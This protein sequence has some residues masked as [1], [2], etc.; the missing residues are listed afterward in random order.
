MPIG[1]ERWPTSGSGCRRTELAFGWLATASPRGRAAAPIW[2]S[3]SRRLGKLTRSLS[4]G[5]ARA[6]Y[7]SHAEPYSATFDSPIEPA[8][9]DAAVRDYRTRISDA[10]PASTNVSVRVTQN[11][12]GPPPCVARARAAQRSVRRRLQIRLMRRHER[13]QV[14]V[15]AAASAADRDLEGG[16]SSAGSARLLGQPAQVPPTRVRSVDRR[17]PPTAA[18]AILR[19]EQRS[20]SESLR[21]TAR[22]ARL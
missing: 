3:A 21:L 20:G 13:T 15:L 9:E 19:R 14:S 10:L 11:R 8:I 12:A 5:S 1:L 17:R 7:G 22:G 16:R 6:S 4:L 18:S 2:R